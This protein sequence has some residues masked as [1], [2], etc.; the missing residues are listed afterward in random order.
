MGVDPTKQ[1]LR[2]GPRD[3]LVG[4][5]NVMLAN[6]HFMRAEYRQAAE[7]ARIALLANPSL[8]LPALTLAAALHRDGRVEEARKI[9][10]EYR[11]R[12]PAF[13]VAHLE[14]RLMLGGEP[15]FAEGRQRMMDSLRALQMP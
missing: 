5:W 1:A 8:P 2:I 14:Q 3:T 4:V 12:I 11:S 15:R 13:R 6:C 9:A 10:D 7:L